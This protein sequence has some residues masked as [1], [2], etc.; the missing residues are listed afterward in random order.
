M[1]LLCGTSV[2]LACLRSKSACE[3]DRVPSC[4]SA[5]SVPIN[6]DQPATSETCAFG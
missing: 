4:K 1:V 5:Q 6:E 2:S 3:F